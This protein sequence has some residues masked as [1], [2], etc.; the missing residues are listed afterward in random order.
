MIRIS[1]EDLRKIFFMQQFQAAADNLMDM[2]DYRDIKEAIKRAKEKI[3]NN[4]GSFEEKMVTVQQLF[5][6]TVDWLEVHGR[7]V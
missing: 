3:P 2:F 4:S 7:R 5:T 6:E 1:Q